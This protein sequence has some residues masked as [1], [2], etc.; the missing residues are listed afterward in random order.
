[1]RVRRHV[2]AAFDR[3]LADYDAVVSP[4]TPRVAPLL[5]ES[6]DRSRRPTTSAPIGAPANLAGV[7]A[8]TVPNGFGERELPTALQFTGRAWTES[9][10]LAVAGAYQARTDWHTRAPG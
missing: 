8:I 5:S 6:L 2:S 10:L 4:T 9:R 7:P 1:M 3:L